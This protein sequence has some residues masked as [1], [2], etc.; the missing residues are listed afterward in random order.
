MA[1]RLYPSYKTEEIARAAR[2]SRPQ[3]ADALGRRVDERVIVVNV[4]TPW[5]VKHGESIP[6]AEDVA[7]VV[8]HKLQLSREEPTVLYFAYYDGTG[9]VF[10][11]SAQ[12]DAIT[13]TRWNHRCKL[14]SHI[15]AAGE[16]RYYIGR[17]VYTEL[18]HGEEHRVDYTHRIELT[19]EDLPQKMQKRPPYIA[20][21]FKTDSDGRLPHPRWVRHEISRMRHPR[22]HR[23]MPLLIRGELCEHVENGKT[24][25]YC[26]YE[27]TGYDDL[28]WR[29]FGW[30]R[31]SYLDW[32]TIGC[33]TYYVLP[34]EGGEF[35]FCD[36]Y[37]T[38]AELDMDDELSSLTA[39]T[40]L[41]DA[42]KPSQINVNFDNPVKGDLPRPAAVREALRDEGHVSSTKD[43]TIYI[44][45]ALPNSPPGVGRI[46]QNRPNCADWTR[47]GWLDG[48][49]VMSSARDSEFKT[50]GL[51]VELDV[52]RLDTDRVKVDADTEF[53]VID[54]ARI[55]YDKLDKRIAS[56]EAKVS[57]LFTQGATLAREIRRL[58]CDDTHAPGCTK[59]N[60][61]DR[62][63]PILKPYRVLK[64]SR[65]YPYT[66]CPDV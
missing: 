2:D 21:N 19:P 53:T 32:T 40:K 66:K 57:A 17:I 15:K 42:P 16:P 33:P 7:R 64:S 52:S 9:S 55:A 6:E 4:E 54:N 18:D 29:H 58:K 45:K 14:C 38:N 13:T 50:G 39:K 56:L 12:S 28:S 1:E 26:I 44:A 8:F 35:S 30:M 24:Y 48:G 65:V 61:E 25:D 27:N 11:Y 49:I 31:M 59:L 20:V 10:I 63:P 37:A 43:A 46:W 36:E 51:N 5:V 3:K 47:Y 41:Q 60:C 23:E 34:N 62:E 22:Y